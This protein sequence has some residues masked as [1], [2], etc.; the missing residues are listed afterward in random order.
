M[1]DQINLKDQSVTNLK[2]KGLVCD[3]NNLK[4]QSITNLK[5]KGPLV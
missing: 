5:L 1:C 3:Q 4:D 2:I